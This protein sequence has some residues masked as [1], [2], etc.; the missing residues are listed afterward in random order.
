ME[1]EENQC[2][3]KLI[4]RGL[5]MSRNCG[6]KPRN[7]LLKIKKKDKH[8][9]QK[10]V[11]AVRSDLLKYSTPQ[12]PFACGAGEPTRIIR[13]LSSARPRAPNAP[14]RHANGRASAASMNFCA[15]WGGKPHTAGVGDL[16]S[17]SAAGRGGHHQGRESP[18][19]PGG[20]ASGVL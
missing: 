12:H 16:A 17:A 19:A 2:A 1:F 20:R 3:P 18:A 14:W 11:K 10:A 8:R 7:D 13:P 6:R 15:A 9:Q 4:Y 5:V